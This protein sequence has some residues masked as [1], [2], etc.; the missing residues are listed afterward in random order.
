MS[1]ELFEKN[2]RDAMKETESTFLRRG[3]EIAQI[4]NPDNGGVFFSKC[5][6]YHGWN[7]KTS[8]LTIFKAAKIARS[9][10]SNE[11]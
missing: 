6:S 11:E 5:I 8:K 10:I 7:E 3:Y 9:R 4:A 2:Y 1:P